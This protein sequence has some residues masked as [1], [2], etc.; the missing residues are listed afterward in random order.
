MKSILLNGEIILYK[1]TYFSKTKQKELIKIL[2]Q[3]IEKQPHV[4]NE[5]FSI[6]L[7]T[8]GVG[9]IIDFGVEQCTE[10]FKNNNGLTYNERWAD[11]WINRIKNETTYQ[12]VTT[13][14]ENAAY[15]IHTELSNNLKKFKPNYTFVYYVQMPDNLTGNEGALLIKNSKGDIYTYHP[16]EFDFI[17]M[18][19]AIPHSPLGAPNSTKD[20]LVIAGNIG[21]LNTKIEK[22]LI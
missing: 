13:S 3:E 11:I 8:D 17:I 2:E 14:T 7:K 22:S 4:I 9:D 20:R 6:S 12:K 21:F 15:H 16:K 19:A 18:D 5:A 10:L 1:T